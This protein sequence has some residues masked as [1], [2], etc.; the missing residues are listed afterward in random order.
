ML[1]IIDFIILV[2]LCSLFAKGVSITGVSRKGSAKTPISPTKH[3]TIKSIFNERLTSL[4]LGATERDIRLKRLN[5]LMKNAI[6]NIQRQCDQDVA[7]FSIDAPKEQID[8]ETNE[9]HQSFNFF[10][11]KGKNKCALLIKILRHNREYKISTLL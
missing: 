11:G 9:N 7:G 3:D 2:L 5:V 8:N 6:T 10:S 1:H 4:Q